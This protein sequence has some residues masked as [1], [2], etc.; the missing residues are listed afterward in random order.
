MARIEN[1]TLET[2]VPRHIQNVWSASRSLTLHLRCT[3]YQTEHRTLA[4]KTARSIVSASPS[5]CL[6][7]FCLYV[8]SLTQGRNFRE[9]GEPFFVQQMGAKLSAETRI[10]PF[11]VHVCLKGRVRKTSKYHVTAFCPALQLFASPQNCL[12]HLNEAPLSG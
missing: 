6:V 11:F 2:N 9:W 1:P 12:Q 4:S 8:T 7:A 5:P 3:V 10:N